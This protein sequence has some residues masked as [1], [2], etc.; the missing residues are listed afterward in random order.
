MPMGFGANAGSLVGAAGSQSFRID[1]PCFARLEPSVT[2][3]LMMI[4][5]LMIMAF[6][7]CSGLR[8]PK[9]QYQLAMQQS[10]LR[11]GFAP[12]SSN[13]RSNPK[14]FKLSSFQ[15]Q[16]TVLSSCLKRSRLY[17]IALPVTL[18]K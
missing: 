9:Q 1:A 10:L 8:C 4:F 5:D 3:L 14:L 12:D 18:C 13:S 6:D 15:K 2:S 11:S 7:A 16:I 17:Q